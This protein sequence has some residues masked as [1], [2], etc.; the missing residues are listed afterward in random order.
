[1]RIYHYTSLDNLALI[2]KNKTIRF[3]RLDRLDD[4]NERNFYSFGLNWSPYTYV[5][6]WTEKEEENIPLWHMYS[7]NGVGIRIAIDKDCIDWGKCIQKGLKET[8]LIRQTPTPRGQKMRILKYIPFAIFGEISTT[9]CYHSIKYYKEPLNTNGMI[10]IGANKTTVL[11]ELTETNFWDYIGLY[12]DVK[13]AFQNEVRFRLF[14]VPI[15]SIKDTLPFDE[16]RNIIAEERPNP[17]TYIDLP[18]KEAAFDNLEITLGPNATEST[19]IIV[20]LLI[21]EFAP[22]AKIEGS[23][24]NSDTWFYL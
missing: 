9:K 13:W 18:L 2:L 3:N 17:F 23:S 5:S 10:E 24:L 8:R 19:S 4:P 20:K 21:K 6:C 22:S 16:F 11:N 15:E 14:A 1:M 7:K 12:K